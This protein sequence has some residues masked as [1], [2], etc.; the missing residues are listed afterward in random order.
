MYYPTTWETFNQLKD[1][2]LTPKKILA[3]QF[4]HTDCEELGISPDGSTPEFT[5]DDFNYIIL[6]QSNDKYI[7]ETGLTVKEILSNDPENKLFRFYAKQYV[8][9]TFDTIDDALDV[10]HNLKN[11]NDKLEHNYFAI[12]RQT[13]S[14]HE[15]YTVEYDEDSEYM[16]YKGYIYTLDED[17]VYDESIKLATY[18]NIIKIFTSVLKK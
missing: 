5:P 13:G 14:S 10:F 8:V 11:S 2:V 18:K 3:R 15:D 7:V 12:K 4:N 6:Y 1:S 9:S 16:Y 17:V